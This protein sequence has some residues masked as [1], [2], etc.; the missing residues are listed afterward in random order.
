MGDRVAQWAV[1]QFGAPMLGFYSP[2]EQICPK[3]RVMPGLKKKFISLI[4][5]SYFLFHLKAS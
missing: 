4:C 5:L 3:I 1:A 2:Q